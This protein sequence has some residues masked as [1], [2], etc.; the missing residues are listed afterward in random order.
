[1][2]D[3]DWIEEFEEIL[4]KKHKNFNYEALDVDKL[5]NA[6]DNIKLDEN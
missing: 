4:P 1:M 2:K 6:V 5:T 3:C